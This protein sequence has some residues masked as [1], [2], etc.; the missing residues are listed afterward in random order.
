MKLFEKIKKIGKR[1]KVAVIA[2]AVAVSSALVSVCAS[3]AT[4]EAGADMSKTLSDAGTQMTGLFGTLVTTLIPVILGI[5]GTGLVIFG[6]MQLI[7]LAK[8]TFG[9]VA[10]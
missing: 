7:K 1:C 9:K 10:G 2:G 6:I 3:A 8:K 5:L 4:T